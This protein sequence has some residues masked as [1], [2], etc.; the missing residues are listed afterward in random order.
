MINDYNYI[1]NCCSVVAMETN[2]FPSCALTHDLFKKPWLLWCLLLYLEDTAPGMQWY[3]LTVH[4]PW[5]FTGE[6]VKRAI[7][8]TWTT[9]NNFFFSTMTASCNWHV[10]HL[11]CLDL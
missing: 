9:C 3:R 2:F 8:G 7:T 11:A 1:H 6:R 5:E 10:R 4:T